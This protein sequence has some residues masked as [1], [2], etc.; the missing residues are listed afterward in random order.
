MGLRLDNLR[1]WDSSNRAEV[2]ATETLRSILMWL[3]FIKRAALSAEDE[4]VG[5]LCVRHEDGGSFRC[6]KKFK[7]L[8][9][10]KLWNIAE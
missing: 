1:S 4:D 5:V 2:L 8:E 7:S 6:A 3:D 9:Q 10:E